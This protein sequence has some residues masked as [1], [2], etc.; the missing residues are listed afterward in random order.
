MAEFAFVRGGAAG[1]GVGLLD[2][3]R[4]AA[5]GVEMGGWLVGCGGAEEGGL[6]LVGCGGAGEG[7]G[8]LGGGGEG[9]G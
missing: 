6:L 2:E 8:D 7:E 4:V 3:E 5:S 1:Q 9:D